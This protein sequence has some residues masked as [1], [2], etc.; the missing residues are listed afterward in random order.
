MES[1]QH[2]KTDTI[3][4]ASDKALVNLQPHPSVSLTTMTSSIPRNVVDNTSLVSPENSSC[5]HEDIDKQEA[6]FVLP[7]LNL[8]VD[9]DLSLIS[10]HGLS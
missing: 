9:E 2:L 1:R 4:V 8:P 7:D 5:K 3:P 6:S 10:T